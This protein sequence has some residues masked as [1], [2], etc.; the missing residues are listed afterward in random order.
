MSLLLSCL[1]VSRAERIMLINPSYN[2]AFRRH[3][4]VFAYLIKRFTLFDEIQDLHSNVNF[5]DRRSSYSVLRVIFLYHIG[6]RGLRV[7][8]MNISSYFGLLI[9]QH[10]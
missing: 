10:L 6:E 7:K 1:P 2:G 3:L 5:E 8:K 4:G 9:F